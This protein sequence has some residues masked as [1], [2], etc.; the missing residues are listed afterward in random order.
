M[1]LDIR[2]ACKLECPLAKID[3]INWL[4]AI[5]GT[6]LTITFS[7]VGTSVLCIRP[8]SSSQSLLKCLLLAL[9]VLLRG[10]RD[11][12]IASVNTETGCLTLRAEIVVRGARVPDEKVTGLSTDFLPLAAVVF[13][14]LQS[15]L[16]K[17]KPFGCPGGNALFVGHFPVKLFGEEMG[18]G[19]DNE[20]TVIGTVGEE[21]DQALKAAEAGLGGV[22]VLVWPWLVGR[23][24]G[25]AVAYK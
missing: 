20:T 15:S 5:A 2:N 16:G 23:E 7:N 9:Q 21:V 14:P 17:S 24:V 1:S 18:A 8:V 12:H 10:I 4:E 13:E 3:S 11:G 6:F 22:L 19:A 25:T